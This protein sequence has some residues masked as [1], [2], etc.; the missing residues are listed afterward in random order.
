V[1]RRALSDLIGVVEAGEVASMRR[2]SDA[3]GPL[4]EVRQALTTRHAA[5]TRY[6]WMCSS[7]RDVTTEESGV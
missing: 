5:T 3:A 2:E 6:A 4:N 7:H 1:S